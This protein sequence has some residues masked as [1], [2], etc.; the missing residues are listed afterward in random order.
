MSINLDTWGSRLEFP[1]SNARLFGLGREKLLRMM[2]WMITAR[3]LDEAEIRLIRQQKV[4][5]QV[6]AAGHEAVQA[7][8]GLLL[9]AGTDWFFPYY[10]DRTLCLALG[11]SPLDMLL[12][13]M[14]KRDDPSSG[15][16][17][18]S[19]HWGNSRLNIV[20]QSSPTGTQ[21]LQAVGTAEAGRIARMMPRCDD[22]PSASS[23]E[24]VY[25]SGGEGSTSE[26]EFF[27]ALSTATI[28]RLPVLFMIEDNKYAISVPVEVQTPAGSISKL[29][30]MYP[31][32][33]VAEVN[34]LDPIASY[35]G[36]RRAVKYVRQGRGPALIHAH[37]IRHYSHSN[38][39]DERFYKPAF[40]RET[41]AA[42]DPVRGFETFLISEGLAGP[43]ELKQMRQS[44]LAEIAEAIQ[45]AET[46]AAPEPDTAM[47]HLY[48]PEQVVVVETSPDPRDGSGSASG[49]VD[50]AVEKQQ[51]LTLVDMINRV[52]GEEMERDPRIIVFGQDVADLTRSEYLDQM[53]GKGGVFKATF[54]LQR[55]FGDHR[56][57]NSPLAE[58]NIVGRAVGMAIRGLRPVVEIQFFDY[59]WPAMMQ[60]RNELGMIRWRSNGSYSAPVVIRVPIGGYVRG[61]ALY[62][63]QSGESI[64]C[65]CPGLRVLFPSNAL[66]A[67]G[68]L[69][70]AVRS[71]DPVIFLEPKHLYRQSYNRAHLPKPDYVIPFGTARIVRPGSDLTVVTYGA[72]VHKSLLAADE[73]ARDGIQVEVI[74]LR[75]LQP[76]DFQTIAESVSRTNRVVVAS[77]ECP[78]FGVAAEIA[79]RI[80]EELFQIL[81]APVS[82]VGGIEAPVGYSPNLE[83]ATLPQVP[84]LLRTFRRVLNF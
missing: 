74:D 55:K 6:S 64:F 57:F 63:S 53:K 77:E 52:L 56:V 60:I 31:G 30:K 49:G 23:Y 62:H 51:E 83:N 15:G 26:G 11:V 76:Y 81:D 14:G 33:Y 44:V 35:R 32:L 3:A 25:V 1:G 38:S 67:C 66:D 10:R 73:L 45:E 70:T 42:S 27:E 47:H 22:R 71:T 13:S 29:V 48:S 69:R 2:R 39:D 40:E 50:G 46:R 78:L 34:G 61:G 18:M 36:L 84:D 7:A 19:N 9:H 59:I 20:N 80:A 4:F 21:Y 72:L 5:F 24:L 17:E 43:E 28:H 37:V 82:R 54:G 41:E 8:A 16:R 58:A 68:L 75:S 12:Q 79:A 65:H